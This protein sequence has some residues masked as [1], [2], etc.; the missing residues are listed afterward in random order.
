MQR[1]EAR[2]TQKLLHRLREVSP[3]AD[4]MPDPVQVESNDFLSMTVG[5]WIIG[6]QLL[7]ET[8]IPRAL[9]VSS[10]NAVERPV[11]TATQGKADG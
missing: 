8:A 2:E 3:T 9:V 4:P 1:E 5:Q 11:G 10:H 7:H 6:A